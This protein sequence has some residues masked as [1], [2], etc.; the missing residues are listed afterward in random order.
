[1]CFITQTQLI[2]YQ[3]ILYTED[4]DLWIDGT[5]CTARGRREATFWKVGS[6][7]ML[8]GEEM[9]CRHWEGEGALIIEKGDKKW[10]AQAY[11]QGEHFS[12]A[13]CQE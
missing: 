3:T 10:S 6:V 2:N 12:K 7:E 4:S 8:F 5:N 11:I 9:D 1:M 13:V